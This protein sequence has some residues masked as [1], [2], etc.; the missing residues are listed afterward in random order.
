MKG[1]NL[2]YGWAGND[3]GASM[4]VNDGVKESSQRA[5]EN[6]ARREFGS[7]WTIHVMQVSIDGDG[8]SVMGVTEVKRFR[9]R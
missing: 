3:Q 1:S 6:A 2:Y 8:Q 9:I 7:G 4:D 5:I